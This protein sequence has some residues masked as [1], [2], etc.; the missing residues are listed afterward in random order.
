MGRIRVIARRYAPAN[1]IDDLVQDILV[2]LWR[3]WPRFRGEAEPTTWV[4]RV[5][6]NAAMTYVKTEIRRRA[7]KSKVASL[8]TAQAIPPGGAE[9]DILNEFLAQLGD[10]DASIM[11]MHLDSLTPCDIAGV[12]GISANAVAIRI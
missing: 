10:I 9:V 6:L 5:A 3:S 4:Y 11:I 2:R 7:L 8:Q 1:A 12:L